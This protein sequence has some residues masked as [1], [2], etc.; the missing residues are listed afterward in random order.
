MKVISLICTN[1]RYR[2]IPGDSCVGGFHPSSRKIDLLKACIEGDKGLVEID[3][4]PPK[5]SYVPLLASSML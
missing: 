2:K 5:V 4:L 3:E 1:F